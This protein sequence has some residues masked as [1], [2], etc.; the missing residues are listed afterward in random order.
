[1]VEIAALRIAYACNVNV[2]TALGHVVPCLVR[3]EAAG[4]NPLPPLRNRV[5][6]ALVSV[7]VLLAVIRQDIP[8]ANLI[9]VAFSTEPDHDN[10]PSVRLV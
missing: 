9:D 1:M 8:R 6:V 10:K 5:D 2:A 7:Q 3:L 4:L